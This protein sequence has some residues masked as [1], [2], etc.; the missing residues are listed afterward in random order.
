MPMNETRTRDGRGVLV[1]QHQWHV[2][3]SHTSDL[4]SV[5]AARSFVDAAE[6]AVRLAGH[7]VSDMRYLPVYPLDPAARCIAMVEEADVYVGII[8]SAYGSLVRDRPELSYTELEF[9]TAT[10]RGLPRLMFLLPCSGPLRVPCRQSAE[11]KGRQRCFRRRLN[12]ARL[13][14]AQATTPL[15]LQF[16]LFHALVELRL[17]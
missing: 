12:E 4:R 9:E 16:A 2:C 6:D 13:M 1:P 7:A 5:P 14:T 11:H 17:R 10:E 8:G 3:L 15:E